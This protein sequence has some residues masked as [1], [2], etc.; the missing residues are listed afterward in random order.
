M[1]LIDPKTPSFKLSGSHYE[2]F[3]FK[4]AQLKI[5]IRAEVFLLYGLLIP[6]VTANAQALSSYATQK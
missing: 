1:F 3:L 6:K 4:K 2:L 5:N